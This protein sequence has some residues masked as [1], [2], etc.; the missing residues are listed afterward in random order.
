ME[1]EAQQCHVNSSVKRF[2]VDS[3]HATSLHHHQFPF[4]VLLL[5]ICC[6]QPSCPH[7][8]PDLAVELERQLPV[9]DLTEN[10]TLEV[11]ADASVELFVVHAWSAG[12]LAPVLRQFQRP[13]DAEFKL[14]A[15]PVEDVAVARVKE[16]FKQVVPQLVLG[17]GAAVVIA[18]T[19]RWRKRQT[20]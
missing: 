19:C 4:H 18:I 16:E 20:A 6:L 13:V 7:I 8:L 17:L 14:V 3:D 1:I 2:H 11:A 9:L 15:G 12:V 5:G 10:A